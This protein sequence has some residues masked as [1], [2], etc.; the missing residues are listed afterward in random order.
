MELTRLPDV[1]TP[2]GKRHHSLDEHGLQIGD[3]VVQGSGQPGRAAGIGYA[4]RCHPRSP[5]TRKKMSSI[6]C[7]HRPAVAV[8][9][10]LPPSGRWRG[11]PA[12]TSRIRG[13]PP[14]PRSQPRRQRAPPR[15]PTAPDARARRPPSKSSL[16]LSTAARTAA[17]E[18][19]SFI[20][21]PE[22]PGVDGRVHPAVSRCPARRI[23]SRAGNLR[24]QVVVTGAAN[25]ARLMPGC[26]G[27]AGL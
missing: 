16:A 9:H 21:P 20:Y 14:S 24:R 7:R 17:R 19:L 11:P 13:S 5:A 8:V 15:R 12:G 23:D 26:P 10:G 27:S 6:T 2:V 3:R 25:P 4:R 22:P 1:V 18:S